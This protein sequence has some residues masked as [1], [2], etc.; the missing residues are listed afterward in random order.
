VQTQPAGAA[1]P[2]SQ[3]VPVA[4]DVDSTIRFLA[5]TTAVP[6]MTRP[7][8]AASAPTAVVAP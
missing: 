1:I 5:E 2:Y 8:A 4:A 6:G 3:Y 7:F